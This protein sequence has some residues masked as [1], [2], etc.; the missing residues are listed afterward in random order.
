MQTYANL[1]G[2]SSVWAFECGSDF[3]R[4]QFTDGAVY[5]Y[6]YVSCGRSACEHMKSLAHA[7][8]G[9]N[10]FINSSVKYGYAR[11]ER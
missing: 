7:G 4:V 8:Q 9:L 3:I 6:T 1:G 2:D 10:A 5:L 11:R